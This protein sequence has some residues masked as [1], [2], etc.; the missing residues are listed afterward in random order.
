IQLTPGG[1]FQVIDKISCEDHKLFYHK[2]GKSTEI[3]SDMAVAC[4]EIPK[5]KKP[6]G[7]AG[8]SSCSIP[9]ETQCA[10]DKCSFLKCPENRWALNDDFFT[11]EIECRKESREDWSDTYWYY[12][13]NNKL[14]KIESASC[15]KEFDC[16][17][18]NPLTFTCEDDECFKASYNKSHLYCPSVY[19]MKYQSISKGAK[20]KI[21]GD[22]IKCNRTTG[23][24][25]LDEGIKANV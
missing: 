14:T 17:E 9:D 13:S 5:C 8:C 10:G 21:A 18:N 2:G 15:Y 4:G 25:I 11:G 16:Q 24:W 1:P 22:F 20:F 23:E 19:S 3:T 6:P 7:I 12:Q